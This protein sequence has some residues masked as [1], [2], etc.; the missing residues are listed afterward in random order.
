MFSCRCL[1]AWPSQIHIATPFLFVF[2]SIPPPAQAQTE[3]KH[4]FTA[5]IVSPS[6]QR[7]IIISPAARRALTAASGDVAIMFCEKQ[8]SRPCSLNAGSSPTLG[9]RATSKAASTAKAWLRVSRRVSKGDPLSSVAQAVRTNLS[10]KA[11]FRYSPSS[12]RHTSA[13]PISHTPN[14]LED[15][16]ANPRRKSPPPSNPEARSPRTHLINRNGC[17][18]GDLALRQGARRENILYGS[19]SDEQRRCSPES[20]RGY[21]SVIPQLRDGYAPSSRLAPDVSGP[22]LSA[23]SPYL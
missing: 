19:L 7:S 9:K 3:L 20:F 13:I 23:A 1:S 16:N 18:A 8:Q 12:T 6:L 22:E 4:T 14:A 21:S 11:Q 10:L 2:T 5:V 17:V 15:P